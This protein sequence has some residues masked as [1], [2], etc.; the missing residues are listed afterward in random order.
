MLK[1]YLILEHLTH[2]DINEDG[3]DNTCKFEIYLK[4]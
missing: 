1:K 4:N 3:N 2:V